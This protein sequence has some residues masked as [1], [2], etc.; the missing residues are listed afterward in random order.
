MMLRR[1]PRWQG[2]ALVFV[3]HAAVAIVIAPA[4][5]APALLE[6]TSVSGAM[7]QLPEYWLGVLS[8]AWIERMHGWEFWTMVVTFAVWSGLATA[9]VAPIVGPVE[10]AASGRSLASSVLA[11]TL[12][13]SAICGLLFA[14]FV[15]MV[16]VALSSDASDFAARHA[17][18]DA[19]I[20]LGALAVWAA[21]GGV[22]FAMLRRVGRSRDPSALDRMLRAVFAGTAV[23]L[24]LGLPIYLMARKKLDC[25]CTTATFLNLVF[26][27]TAL[28]WLCGPWAILLVT[29]EA[30]RNWARGACT[31][32]GY[33]RRSG[34]AVCSECGHL[35]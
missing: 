24:V 14:T 26:G 20:W 9:F 15:E 29:R 10:T 28:L 5:L 35:H 19:M 25:Y 32:C 22:W 2:L 4:F 11:A 21:S 7:A 16:L 8:L 12:I 3:A 23:E 18:A 13:G 31:A 27:T 33:P 30:R 34:A 17:K 1:M 6:V